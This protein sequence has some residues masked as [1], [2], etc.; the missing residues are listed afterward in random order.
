[1]KQKFSYRLT[2]T[3]NGKKYNLEYASETLTNAGAFILKQLEM[4]KNRKYK[5]VKNW[6]TKKYLVYIHETKKR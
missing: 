1:M 6:K 4:N 5:I 3:F 2:R